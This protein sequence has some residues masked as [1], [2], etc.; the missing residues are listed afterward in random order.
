MSKVYA[1]PAEQVRNLFD[2]KAAGWPAKYAPDGP[3][4]GRLQT[5]QTIT[6]RLVPAGG[7]VLDLGCGTGEI[8]REL[9]AVGMHVAGC[10]ISA[11]MLRTAAARG[12]EARWVQLPP[13]WEH[14]PFRSCA[15]DALIASSV[16]EYVTDP[17]AVLNEC[18]RVLH[19]RGVLLATV[20]DTRH[21]IRWL[22]ALAAAAERTVPERPTGR[23]WQGYR[24]YLR[25]S[26]QRHPARWWLG[27]ARTAGLCPVRG[28]AP[29]RPAPL[30]M[31]VLRHIGSAGSGQ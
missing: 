10:D 2:G 12:P 21:P 13:S 26:R 16:L 30:R 17:L 23:R 25:T 31:L 6:A 4:A 11:Q 9:A 22:E 28:M 14:L 15:F 1:S 18:S 20:P 8:A 3:L 19:P 24:A 29:D 5:L 27:A 7:W